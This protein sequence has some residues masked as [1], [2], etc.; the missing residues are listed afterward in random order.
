MDTLSGPRVFHAVIVK[1]AMHDSPV[2]FI[3]PQVLRLGICWTLQERLLVC[4]Y[5]FSCSFR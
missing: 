3:N 1:Y 4:L 2:F 5:N